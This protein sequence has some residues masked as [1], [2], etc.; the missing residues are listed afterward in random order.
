M[1]TYSA[2]YNIFF[3]SLTSFILTYTYLHIVVLCRKSLTT[4]VFFKLGFFLLISIYF[5]RM[6]PNYL[7]LQFQK[8]YYFTFFSN[9]CYCICMYLCICTCVDVDINKLFVYMYVHRWYLSVCKKK[10]IHL[11]KHIYKFRHI[12]IL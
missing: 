8:T 4:Y 11:V 12:H 9:I 10:Y 7:K 5:R 1:G 3:S 6:Y 2:T